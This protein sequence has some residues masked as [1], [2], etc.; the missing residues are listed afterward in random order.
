MVS[1]SLVLL[2]FLL[3]FHGG[4]Q[5]SCRIGRFSV[6]TYVCT[7]VSPPSLGHP[8]TPEAQ[9]ANQPGLTRFI[10][11][12]ISILIW[13]D[14]LAHQDFPFKKLFFE[15]FEG[16]YLSENNLL[17]ITEYTI[18]FQFLFAMLVVFLCGQ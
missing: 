5:G 12:S 13:L 9:P 18:I 16:I 17:M 8:A 7:Y 15:F 10:T 2:Y 11:D 4:R 6:F 1:G 3:G 14:R